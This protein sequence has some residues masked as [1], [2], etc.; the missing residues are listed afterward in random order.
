[1]TLQIEVDL[2]G[3]ILDLKETVDGMNYECVRR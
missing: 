2:C 1:M 3:E